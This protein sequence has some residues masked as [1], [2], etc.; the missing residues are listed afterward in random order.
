M[1]GVSFYIGL[2]IASFRPC[3]RC[4][5]LSHLDPE[6]ELMRTLIDAVET[7]PTK[8][9][10]DYDF[11]ELGV[12]SSTIRRQFKKRF[13]MTFIAYARA[14]RMDIV[15]K[16]IRG[17]NSVINTQVNT[18]YESSSGF[19]DA[20]S[21]IMGAPPIKNK[22]QYKILNASRL[23]TPIGPMIAIG[24]DDTLYLLEFIDRRGLEKEIERLRLKMKAAIVPGTTHSIESI[25]NEL[26]LYFTEGLQ[27]FTTPIHLL[28]SPFQ[29]N[30]WHEL[31]NIPYGE[32]RS[33][34]Q[35]SIAI[36]NPK[37]TR[38]VANANG[39]NQ[40]AIII[41]CHRIIRNNGELGGYR[42]GVKRKKWLIAHEKKTYSMLTKNKR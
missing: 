38:A 11:K 20:F 33:Y 36:G 13:N 22:Q 21:K 26:S 39:A 8:R 35:Q 5:P 30:V 41:P 1:L 31:I 7:N 27:T 29:Q 9:W 15:F 3:M 18:G 2:A 17:E 42:G 24:D 4:H 12:D 34:V 19:R 23:D 28:G 37:A 10:N 40:L 14:R 25:N 16:Q 32:T 6:S